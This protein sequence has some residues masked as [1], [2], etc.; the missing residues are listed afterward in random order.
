MSN[1]L[2]VSAKL[3]LDVSGFTQNIER[4]GRLVDEMVKKFDT[5]DKAVFRL[6]GQLSQI[7][8]VKINAKLSK[9]HEDISKSLWIAEEQAKHDVEKINVALA[10]VR[11]KFSG[12]GGDI[13]R[14]QGIMNDFIKAVGAKFTELQGAINVEDLQKRMALIAGVFDSAIKGIQQNLEKEI[15]RIQTLFDGLGNS[16]LQMGKAFESFKNGDVIDNSMSKKIEKEANE[17]VKAIEKSKQEKTKAIDEETKA[18]AKSQSSQADRYAMEIERKEAALRGSKTTKKTVSEPIKTDTSIDASSKKAT[19]NGNNVVD[20]LANMNAAIANANMSLTAFVAALDGNSTK[21][22]NAFER[23]FKPFDSISDRSKASLGVAKEMAEGFGAMKISIDEFATGVS[24]S[25]RN[26]KN[27]I[28]EINAI[29][30]NTKQ[31][32]TAVKNAYE[33][34]GKKTKSQIEDIIGLV[35]KLNDAAEKIVNSGKKIKPAVKNINDGIAALKTKKDF[36]DNVSG[37][38]SQL[39]KL[40]SAADALATASSSL[41]GMKDFSYGDTISKKIKSNGDKTDSILS[42]VSDVKQKTVTVV[43][44]MSELDGNFETTANGISRSVDIIKGRFETLV[45][46]T[47]D[48][49]QRLSVQNAFIKDSANGLL[50]V[51]KTFE[52]A[53]LALTDGY[54]RLNAYINSSKTLANNTKDVY[55]RNATIITNAANGIMNN[56]NF[57]SLAADAKGLSDAIA[58]L[59]ENGPKLSSALKGITVSRTTLRNLQ[60]LMA[61]IERF[62]KALTGLGSMASGTKDVFQGFGFGRKT[63]SYIGDIEKAVKD[64]MT[65]ADKLKP[66]SQKIVDTFYSIGSTLEQNSARIENASKAVATTINKVSARI[67]T[68]SLQLKRNIEYFDLFLA[69]ISKVDPAVSALNNPVKNLRIEFTALKNEAKESAEAIGK[70]GSSKIQKNMIDGG[71]NGGNSGSGS[72]GNG[73]NGGVSGWNDKFFRSSTSGFGS[74]SRAIITVNQGLNLMKS[75]M[76]GIGIYPSQVGM[77]FVNAGKKVED[78]YTRILF[79]TRSAQDASQLVADIGNFAAQ[80]P[81]NYDQI[82]EGATRFV[83]IVQGADPIGQTKEWMKIISDLAA[84]SGLSVEETTSQVIRMYSA[85]AQAADMFRERGITAMLGFKANTKYLA[86]ETRKMLVDAYN[87]PDSK[88]KGASKAIATNLSGMFSMVSDKFFLFQNRMMES[89]PMMAIKN[90][91]GGYVRLFDNLNRESNKFANEFGQKL[92]GAI[93]NANYKFVAFSASVYEGILNISSALDGLKESVGDDSYGLG[94]DFVGA[95]FIGTIAYL[96]ARAHPITAAIVA[97]GVTLERIGSIVNSPLSLDSWLY[98]VLTLEGKDASTIFDF[99]DTIDRAIAVQIVYWQSLYEAMSFVYSLWE[100]IIGNLGSKMQSFLESKFGLR[101]EVDQDNVNKTK[102]VIDKLL[103]VDTYKNIGNDIKVFFDSFVSELD[104]GLDKSKDVISYGVNGID[105]E[106]KDGMLILKNSVSTQFQSLITLIREESFGLAPLLKT[107]RNE[108]SGALEFR[109]KVS[110][111]KTNTYTGASNKSIDYEGLPSKE[112][113]IQD[114]NR[115]EALHGLKVD[116]PSVIA[117]NRLTKSISETKKKIAELKQKRI[118]LANEAQGMQT[119][120]QIATVLSQLDAQYSNLNGFLAEEERLKKMPKIEPKLNDGDKSDKKT[121]SKIESVLNKFQ[122]M[123]DKAE[124]G[125]GQIEIPEM[126][127]KLYEQVEKTKDLM[128][129]LDDLGASGAIKSAAEKIIQDIQ[130]LGEQTVLKEGDKE[131]KDTFSGLRYEL[132]QA[133]YTSQQTGEMFESQLN[134]KLDD[135]REKFRL[136]GKYAGYFDKQ[137]QEY[138]ETLRNIHKQQVATQMVDAFKTIKRDAEKVGKT[139][140]HI[141][142]IDHRNNVEDTITQ[143]MKDLNPTLAKQMK[144]YMDYIHES[145][146][147]VDFDDGINAALLNAQNSLMTFGEATQ[148]FMTDIFSGLSSGLED[149]F[150][151]IFKG[152]LD[153]AAE[154]MS[155]F[156]DSIMQSVAQIMSNQIAAQMLSGVFGM[157]G[158]G[159]KT[160]PST[161]GGEFTSWLSAFKHHSGGIVSGTHNSRMRVNAALFNGAP[162]FH[163]GLMSD[164]FP[165]ILQKGEVVI[166]KNGFKTQTSKPQNV[167]VNIKNES[168][169]SLKITK[170][171]SSGDMSQTIIDVVVDGIARNRSGLR[172]MLSAR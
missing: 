3:E 43:S 23:M 56:V 22:A 108:V 14:F 9:I 136:A 65:A 74:I 121:E 48:L 140:K 131:W 10:G 138:E 62:K 150:F 21:A 144:E 107:I 164:E 59:K 110:N 160:A 67:A 170:S 98:K 19:V 46:V 15:S 60:S 39:K 28:G 8:N 53:I 106:F 118:D 66:F 83:G 44:A 42:V 63:A 171:T 99:S 134:Q 158:G 73:R 47:D 34:A 32:G 11:M 26:I 94:K 116:D 96:F 30:T 27:S 79:L 77:S 119:D 172:D 163:N 36:G 20:F 97:I 45:S 86:T 148:T 151:N 24:E 31:L 162:R 149:C 133:G 69:T 155:S 82:L 40:A 102:D 16:I 101:V 147:L 156:A 38:V 137:L 129:E 122:K 120:S 125:L 109:Y 123:K 145:S 70:I 126:Q 117:V 112:Q 89:G 132:E 142:D 152:N 41:R 124:I 57:K 111:V 146:K 135:M 143:E 103:S 90:V 166:P 165:A 54:K 87:V 168:G 55:G 49:S 105:F 61:T 58:N 167:T 17:T 68:M 169:E 35:G 84:V 5:I 50:E 37:A 104:G 33:E 159:T 100:K 114:V 2:G 88:I 85:G 95:G 7:G 153:D 76:A 161:G 128:E 127:Q 52:I 29:G 78:L 130:A 64:Y 72:G 139:D 6:N 80:V 25:F 92:G 4:V 113:A 154:A 13:G 18:I 81:F 91:V 93:E 157:F 75:L 115:I 51:S 141:A 1:D 12:L 71:G